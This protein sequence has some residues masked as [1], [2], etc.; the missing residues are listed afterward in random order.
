MLAS[1]VE[2]EA[3]GCRQPHPRGNLLYY[4][5]CSVDDQCVFVIFHVAVLRSSERGHVVCETA[6]VAFMKLVQDKQMGNFFPELLFCNQIF[7]C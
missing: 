6:E 1:Y 5:G 2:R 7:F 3:V 4:T